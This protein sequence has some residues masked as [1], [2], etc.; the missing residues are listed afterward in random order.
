MS[1]DWEIA[2]LYAAEVSR[3]DPEVVL[4]G[5]TG[6][7]YRQSREQAEA[8][9]T[10]GQILRARNGSIEWEGDNAVPETYEE[11]WADGALA[12]DPENRGPQCPYSGSP[13]ATAW[14]NG[15]WWA[16]RQYTEARAATEGA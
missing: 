3:G 8:V 2:E 1:S 16:Q 11:R 5:R 6:R 15:Y 13:E 12:F 9:R 14:W 10:S 4:T 7:T